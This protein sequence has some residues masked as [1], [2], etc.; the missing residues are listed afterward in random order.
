MEFAGSRDMATET[1]T[2]PPRARR[3][4]EMVRHVTD[5]IAAFRR[6]QTTRKEA[7]VDRPEAPPPPRE[8]KT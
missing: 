3:P 5:T 6:M 4:P 7:R 8:D 1:L 2:R